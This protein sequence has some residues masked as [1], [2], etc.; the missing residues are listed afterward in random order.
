[1][2][3]LMAGGV[4][5]AYLPPPIK[6]E[7]MNWNN[8]TKDERAEYMRLQMSPSYVGMRSGYLPDD[9]SECGACGQ[10]C[11]GSVGW[12]ESCLHRKIELDNKLRC[13]STPTHKGGER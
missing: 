2:E 3:T 8:L 1:M 11:F 7:W 13:I 4:L 5:N 10:P 9:C 12:C 6:E